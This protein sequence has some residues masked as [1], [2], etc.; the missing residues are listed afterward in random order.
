M[1]KKIKKSEIDF[2]KEKF[3]I[4]YSKKKGWNPN[5]LTISQMLEIASK[6]DYRNP[7][8]SVI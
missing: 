7:K 2:F 3:L 4:E 5:E 1:G 8:I 6:E